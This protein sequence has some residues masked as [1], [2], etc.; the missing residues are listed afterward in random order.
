MVEVQMNSDVKK[1][2][3]KLM[4]GLTV[5]QIEYVGLGLVVGIAA[6]QYA[7]GLSMDSRVTFAFGLALPVIIC[8]FIKVY[9]MYLDQYLVNLFR[10]YVLRPKKRIY[11]TEGTLSF[12][13]ENE[14]DDPADSKGTGKKEKK[15]KRNLKF[16]DT[17]EKWED[18][19]PKG[20]K[21][22]K[23]LFF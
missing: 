21:K 9:G 4:L 13:T 12:L 8:G 19:I 16:I 20:Q 23:F 2:E 1:Y 15:K 17:S 14:E 7:N 11:S 6:F 5:R 22:K 10:G 18:F 3:P